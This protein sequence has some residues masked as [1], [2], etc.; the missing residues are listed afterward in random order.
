ML[1]VSG[2]Q[3]VTSSLDQSLALINKDLLGLSNL[4]VLKKEQILDDKARTM[5]LLDSPS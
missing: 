1:Q 5:I 4:V 3:P 2:W